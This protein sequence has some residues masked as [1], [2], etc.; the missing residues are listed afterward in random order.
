VAL[1]KALGGGWDA[2]T[3]P[4]IQGESHPQSGAATGQ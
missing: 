2:A 4:A 3:L 1:I